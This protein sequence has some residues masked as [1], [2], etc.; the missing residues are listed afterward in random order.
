M[1]LL[2]EVAPAL[3]SNFVGLPV[4]F[5]GQI[6][7]TECQVEHAVRRCGAQDCITCSVSCRLREQVLGQQKVVHV[8]VVGKGYLRWNM[9][10]YMEHQCKASD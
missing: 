6:R 7:D 8:E 2:Q 4:A 9:V 1:G 10:E 3:L 5:G